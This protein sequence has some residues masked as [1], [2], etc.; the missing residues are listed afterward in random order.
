MALIGHST[1]KNKFKYLCNYC[2]G[3]K[4]LQNNNLKFFYGYENVPDP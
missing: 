2:V 1:H 4:F 3:L